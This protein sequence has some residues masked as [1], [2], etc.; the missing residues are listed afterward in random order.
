MLIHKLKDLFSETKS[1]QLE[2]GHINSILYVFFNNFE[3]GWG[4][5]VATTA[6][7]RLHF[8]CSTLRIFLWSC[9]QLGYY[10]LFKNQPYKQ[11]TFLQYRAKHTLPG[12]FWVHT[13]NTTY[14]GHTVKQQGMWLSHDHTQYVYN[15][16]D[17]LASELHYM[18]KS[19]IVL[20]WLYL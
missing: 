17:L 16:L 10:Y 2:S 15:L 5:L 20:L 3:G 14:V 6:D 19:L 1:A 11:K 4:V 13:I 18:Q 12:G 8:W 7:L 9:M